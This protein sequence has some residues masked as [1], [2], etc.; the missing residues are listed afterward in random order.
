MRSR[1]WTWDTVPDAS[2]YSLLPGTDCTAMPVEASQLA[3]ELYR[4]AGTPNWASYSEGSRNWPY[5][6][7]AGSYADAIYASTP[8]GL[9]PVS[10]TPIPIVRVG[11]AGP[12]NVALDSPC[13]TF[14]VRTTVL[15]SGLLL[16]RNPDC[17]SAIAAAA[18]AA[19][20]TR[21]E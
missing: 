2:M 11:S 3:V 20:T 1:L 16:I 15:L 4:S 18:L 8:A 7:L 17:T 10:P 21:N 5:D 14:V 13:K 9:A 6:A 12:T 19:A